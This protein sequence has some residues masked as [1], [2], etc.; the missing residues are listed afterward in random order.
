[1]DDTVIRKAVLHA[2]ICGSTRLYE[3]HGDQVARADVA[4]CLGILDSVT[5]RCGGRVV[6]TVG[7]EVVCLFAEPNH[8]LVAAGEMQEAVHEASERGRFAS[9]AMRIKIGWHYGVVYEEDGEV[10]GE[11]TVTAPQVIGMAKADQVLLSAQ[12]LAALPASLKRG[13]RFVDRV[14]ASAWSGSL[15]VWDLPWEESDDLTQ[16]GAQAPEGKVIVH[17]SLLLE[18][19]ASRRR[20]DASRAQATLGRGDDNDVTVYGRFASRDHASISLRNGRFHL[21]DNSTNGTVLVA[22]DGTRTRL[23]RESTML[24]DSGVICLG[25]NPEE[26]PEAVSHFRCE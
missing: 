25:A 21:H 17:H 6:K 3:Q 23:H 9:G 7:D 10:R 2:D 16:V 4:A 22:A 11:A 15:E 20:L 5:E 18:H 19:G 24:P 14:A 26:D 1:M 8:A 12:A 13:A